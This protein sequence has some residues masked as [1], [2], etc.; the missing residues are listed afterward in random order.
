MSTKTE[1]KY[2]ILDKTLPVAMMHTIYLITYMHQGYSQ[3]G[4][5]PN[6][7][8]SGPASFQSYHLIKNE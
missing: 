6:Q 2:K 7:L 8:R 3:N 1:G 4:M 5:Y